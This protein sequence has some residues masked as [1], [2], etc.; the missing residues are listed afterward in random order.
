MAEL[1][2]IYVRPG[3]RRRGVGEMITVALLEWATHLGFECVRLDTVP[4]LRAAR[5][6]YARLGFTPIPP[7]RDGLP[8]DAICLERA[9]RWR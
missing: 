5:A 4:E 3:A 9:V 8:A 7:Y 6:L 2:R 1:K